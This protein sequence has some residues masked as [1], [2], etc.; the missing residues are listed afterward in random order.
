MY[1]LLLQA[2]FSKRTIE[3]EKGYFLFTI[4]IYNVNT[5]QT[6]NKKI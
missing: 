3:N 4:H 6:P 5:I 1:F 2:F